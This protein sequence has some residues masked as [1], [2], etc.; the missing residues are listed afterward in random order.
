MDEESLFHRAL[1]KPSTERA[2]FLDGA[3]GEDR[4]LRRRLEVLLAAHENP[5]SLLD[6]PVVDPSAVYQG[7]ATSDS[8]NSA[9]E[10][11]LTVATSHQAAPGTTVAGR[12]RLLESIGEGGMGTVWMAEQRDPV[13]RLVALKLIKSGMATKI[14]V[15][16]FEAERQALALMDHPN[17]ARV[18]DAG[19]ADDGCPFFVMELV[20]GITLTQYCDERRQSIPE[21]LNLFI[22]ICQA[23]QHAHQKGIIHRDLKPTNI[24]I[25]EHDGRPVPKVIDFGLAKALQGGHALTDHTLY[26]AFGAIVGTPLYMAPEQVGINSLDVDTR[27]DIYALGVILYELLTGSTPLERQRFK[28]AAWDEIC[29]LI[30]EEEPPKPSTRLSSSDAMPSIAAC[31]H[32]EPLKLGR[33]LRG[34][35]DWIVLKSLEKDRDRRYET[36]SSL[37]VDVQRHLANEPVSAGPPSSLYRFRKMVRR[38]RLVFAAA[39]AVVAALVIGTVV[40]THFAIVAHHQAD[41]ARL[42]AEVALREKERADNQAQQAALGREESQDN[43]CASLYN[44]ARAAMATTQTGR[45]WVALDLLRK[46]ES[47]RS[48]NRPAVTPT[49]GHGALTL[50]T[51]ADLRGQAVAALLTPDSHSI[52]QITLGSF[53]ESFMGMPSVVSADGRIAAGLWLARSQE[54]PDESEF[55]LRVMDVTSNRELARHAV[56]ADPQPACLALSP[57]GKLLA[58][59]AKKSTGEEVNGFELTIWELPEFRQLDRVWEWPKYTPSDHPEPQHELLFNPEGGQLAMVRHG[60]QQLDVVIWN[61]RTGQAHANHLQ[62][63][64]GGLWPPSKFTPD[65]I[66]LAIWTGTKKM[67]MLKLEGQDSPTEIELPLQ[68]VNVAFSPR[69][70]L[71]AA[72]NMYE[73]KVVLWDYAKNE[74]RSRMESSS[75]AALAFDPLGKRL[76][77]SGE[78][79]ISIYE[80]PGLQRVLRFDAGLPGDAMQLLQ[81]LPDGQHLISISGI[82]CQLNLWELSSGGLVSAIPSGGLASDFLFSPDGKW[83]AVHPGDGS[84]VRLVNRNNGKVEQEFHVVDKHCS[85]VFRGDS[86]QLAFLSESGLAVVND[87][88]TRKEVVR[89]T[90]NGRCRSGV[91]NPDGQLLVAVFEN[92][93]YSIWNVSTNQLAGKPTT[94]SQLGEPFS[95]SDEPFFCADGRFMVLRSLDFSGRTPGSVYELATGKRVAKLQSTQVGPGVF[96]GDFKFSP[97][98]RWAVAASEKVPSMGGLPRRAGA[99]QNEQPSLDGVELT[100]ESTVTMWNLLTGE[101]RWT[102]PSAQHIWPRA[103][104]PDG[105]WLALQSGENKFVQLWTTNRGDELFRFNPAS[106]ND[107]TFTPDGK[108]LAWTSKSKKAIELLDIAVLRRQLK[109]IGLD[110]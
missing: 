32:T 92:P 15:A 36:A 4:A 103:F 81:W 48:R 14:V 52:R 5:G 93:Y 40:A 78:G 8:P 1:K 10:D 26:T 12:Y 97:D 42:S 16:R 99:N 30:R 27:T 19:T 80:L 67:S 53:E 88:Q 77:V 11:I 83:I 35:L 59:G 54:A 87:L 79:Q 65:G 58:M 85:L 20:R 98:S 39:S 76:A 57:N 71:L 60:Y 68:M 3:C 84:S 95:K 9:S 107:S 23:V 38:N 86:Q 24:L 105:R 17:I 34:D 75:G 69:D 7:T 31:R 110:W 104:N 66:S 25:T 106:G 62:K 37:A 55:S 29:R 109:E 44:Q 49:S 2:A 21:R 51:R 90:M 28:E 82:A 91:F 22:Q 13:K 61:V 70:S 6:R 43:L 72:H 41:E 74:E 73:K 108:Y 96:T 100:R 47:L 94:D 102:I 56:K 18:Y 50:P 101:K 33:L 89:R 64:P 63:E 46:A 45:R